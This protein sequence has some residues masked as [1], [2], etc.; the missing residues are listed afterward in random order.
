[1]EYSTNSKEIQLGVVLHVSHHH[2]LCCTFSI[3][4]RPTLLMLNVI[5]ALNLTYRVI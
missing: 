5:G 3:N 1:M 4:N 2:V